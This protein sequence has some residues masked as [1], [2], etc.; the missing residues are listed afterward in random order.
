M[1]ATIGDI[2]IARRL[3]D[4]I[5]TTLEREILPS[6]AE[7]A[8]GMLAKTTNA[9]P[10]AVGVLLG[11]AGGLASAAGWSKEEFLRHAGNGYTRGHARVGG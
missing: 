9:A 1:K 4:A 2:T 6:P 10:I 3:G 5:M 11:I 7:A 8:T